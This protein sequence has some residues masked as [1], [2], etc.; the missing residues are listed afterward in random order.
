MTIYKVH[1]RSNTGMSLG[2]SFHA[3]RVDANDSK[4]VSPIEDEDD[5]L[6]DVQ[7]IDISL[8]K[9]AVI[10]ALNNHASHPDNG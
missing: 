8:S 7:E 6:K 5:F 1:H 10:A 4:A 2:F 9:K 3:N